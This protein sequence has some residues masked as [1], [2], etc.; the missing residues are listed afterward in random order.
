L[1]ELLE[2]AAQEGQWGDEEAALLAK[3]EALSADGHE[4]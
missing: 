3:L 2:V 1:I 4:P